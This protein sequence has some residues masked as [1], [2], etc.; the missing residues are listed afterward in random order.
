MQH[1]FTRMFTGNLRLLTPIFALTLLSGCTLGSYASVLSLSSVHAYQADC[2][3]ISAQRSIIDDAK[4][5][6]LREL[7]QMNQNQS[8]DQKEGGL[9]TACEF[10]DQKSDEA[11]NIVE[12]ELCDE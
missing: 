6:I 7:G 3:T 2:L 9:E 1:K 8:D 5:E 4:K 12:T 11:S 10:E